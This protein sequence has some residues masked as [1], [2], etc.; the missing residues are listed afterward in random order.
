MTEF[1][2]LAEKQRKKE[3]DE[4][5]SSIARGEHIYWDFRVW[6]NAYKDGKGKENAKVFA[7]YLKSRGVE[8]TPYQRKWIGENCFGFK[9]EYNHE[10]GDYDITKKE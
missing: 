9:F 1:D 7:E 4:R 5:C 2:L 3:N 6:C 8:L 10:K